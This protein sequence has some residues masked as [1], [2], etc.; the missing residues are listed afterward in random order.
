MGLLYNSRAGFLEKF[1]LSTNREETLKELKPGTDPYYYFH[2]LH[3]QNTNRIE[4]ARLMLDEWEKVAKENEAVSE[5]RESDTYD[6]DLSE[7]D[8]ISFDD[9]DKSKPLKELEKDP[10]EM[11][12]RALDGEPET[13][14]GPDPF[15]A[16]MSAPHWPSQDDRRTLPPWSSFAFL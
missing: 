8:S 10:F 13:T 16:A 14:S 12:M 1:A 9:D 6:F 2:C 4:E 11:A 15:E 7:L 5:K 3:Y